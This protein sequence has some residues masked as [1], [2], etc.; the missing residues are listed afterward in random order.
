VPEG[1]CDGRGRDPSGCARARPG[2]DGLSSAGPERW[3]E[4]GC[5]APDPVPNVGGARLVAPTSSARE[6]TFSSRSELTVCGLRCDAEGCRIQQF[7]RRNPEST[8]SGSA[9][10]GGGMVGVVEDQEP[11]AKRGQGLAGCGTS[12]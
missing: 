7:D 4:Q 6:S 12:P 8:S 2:S 9:V 10:G 3:R 11:V 1:G 5:D